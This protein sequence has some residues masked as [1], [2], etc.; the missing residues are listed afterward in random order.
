[1]GDFLCFIEDSLVG[2]LLA[3]RIDDEIVEHLHP[4]Q[5]CLF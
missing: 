5:S 4:D 2:L 1:M 3:V